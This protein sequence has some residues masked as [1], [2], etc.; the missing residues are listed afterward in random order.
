MDLARARVAARPPVLAAP[1]I[2]I[3]L[4]GEKSDWPKSLWRVRASAC[5]MIFK[6]YPGGRIHRAA[7]KDSRGQIDSL[8]P[9]GAT[10]KPKKRPQ[11]IAGAVVPEHYRHRADGNGYSAPLTKHYI[12][13]SFPPIR[14]YF[15]EPYHFENPAVRP[16]SYFAGTICRSWR[17]A[18]SWLRQTI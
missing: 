9:G 12:H 7:A 8:W 10:Q 2:C 5:P 1:F 18:K 15:R 16:P 3:V 11:L 4:I 6:V 13:K 14:R 17:R